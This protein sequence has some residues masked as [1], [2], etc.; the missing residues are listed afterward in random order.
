M[1]RVTYI[2][3]LLN[4]FYMNKIEGVLEYLEEFGRY[5]YM[6]NI[7]RIGGKF[8]HLLIKIKNPRSI[9]EIGTSN[10][11]ST[12]WLGREGNKVITIEG[13]KNKV[14]MAKENFEAC[15]LKNIKVIH[16]DALQVLNKLKGQFDFVFID[17]RKDDYLKYF[18]LIKLG[19][20]A[21]VVADNIISHRDN[22]KDYVDYVR[23]NYDSFLLEIGNGLEVSFID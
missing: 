15:G 11:Y 5:N 2:N 17:A 8:L 6:F 16:G 20:N 18:K 14:N 1:N 9:L 4:Y 13:D 3:M 21:V 22:V 12:I 10:G 19:K 23:K 7:P